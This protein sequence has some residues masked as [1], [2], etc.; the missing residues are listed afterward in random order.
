MG[1]CSL[2][3]LSEASSCPNF[4]PEQLGNLATWQLRKM[5]FITWLPLLTTMAL[6]LDRSVETDDDEVE[7][8]LSNRGCPIKNQTIKTGI[9]LPSECVQLQGKWLRPWQSCG[10]FCT[11]TRS[12][13]AWTFKGGRCN[14]Y[15]NGQ[16]QCG[17][18]SRGG[19]GTI[20]GYTGCQV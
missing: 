11:R 18:V 8:R 17:F 1:V 9:V 20:A 16:K 5:H 3:R 2:N 10:A 19:A 15:K 6:A 12:C 7:R 14:L 13:K 4:L